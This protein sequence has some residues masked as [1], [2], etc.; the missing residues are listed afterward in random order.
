MV[1]MTAQQKSI[2]LRIR[3]FLTSYVAFSDPRFADVCALWVMGTHV[4]QRFDSFGYLVITAATKRAGKSVLA[5]L[6]SMLSHQSKMGSGLSA[7]V[8]REY[9]S[10][11]NTVFFDESET[12]NSEAAGQMRSYLNIGY[13]KGQMIPVRTSPTE[14]IEI[15]AYSPKAFI[16]IGDVN[17]TLRDRSVVIEMIRVA[18]PPQVYR[19]SQAL[20]EA[21]EIIGAIDK[22][23]DSQMHEAI[24]SA[25]KG[26]IF[27]AYEIDVLQGREG[28]VWTTILSL[29]QAFCPDRMNTIIAC[30]TDLAAIKQTTEKRTFSDIRIEAENSANVDL[31]S[32][33]ALRDL[34]SVFKRSEDRIASMDAIER[35]K[36][37]PTS[38][39]RT[40][41]GTG[42]DATMLGELLNIHFK[43]GTTSTKQ[44]KT[45]KPIRMGKKIVR[46]YYRKDVKA[47]F[48]KLGAK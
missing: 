44:S 35:M 17:D 46:G 4:Y 38:P 6:M 33:Y 28:E 48:D 18:R 21:A 36:A 40:Y 42:L 29:A 27:D 34:M 11:G 24:N 14:I 5:E 22:H 13:R 41:K 2:F 37:I 10:K 1:T 8:M 15:P 19:Y 26:E 25:Y 45:T 16:L 23:G 47:A 12:A 20:A 9:I 7:S 43:K 3:D 31:F 32:D 30:A 39:W